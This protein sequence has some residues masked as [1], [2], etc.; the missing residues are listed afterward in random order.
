MVSH[1]TLMHRN[2]TIAYNVNSHRMMA[3]HEE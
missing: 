1:N 3:Q 2:G